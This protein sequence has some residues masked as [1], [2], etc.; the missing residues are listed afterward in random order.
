MDGTNNGKGF[1]VENAGVFNK[2][3]T[4]YTHCP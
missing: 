2:N 3:I 4:H 1:V